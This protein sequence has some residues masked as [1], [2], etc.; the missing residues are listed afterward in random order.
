[1][2]DASSRFHLLAK[3]PEGAIMT[4]SLGF[5]LV[6]QK[7]AFLIMISKS[8]NENSIIVLLTR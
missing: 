2:Q 5:E 6:P 8:E 3:I 4:S 1:M 7:C